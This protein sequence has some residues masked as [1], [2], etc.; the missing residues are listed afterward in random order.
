MQTCFNMVGYKGVENVLYKRDNLAK[1]HNLCSF[2]L[3][4]NSKVCNKPCLVPLKG[5]L[6]DAT[7]EPIM[8]PLTT[9][10]VNEV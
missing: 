4:T 8:I 7:E 3:T 10:L 1:K 9:L 2:P 5:S 6:S